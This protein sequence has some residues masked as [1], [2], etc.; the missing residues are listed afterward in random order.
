VSTNITGWWSCHAQHW[1][2]A[3]RVQLSIYIVGR[4][5]GLV[6]HLVLQGGSGKYVYSVDVHHRQHH[7]SNHRQV[8][9]DRQRCPV[10]VVAVYTGTAWHQCWYRH[11]QIAVLNRTG[12]AMNDPHTHGG[13]GGGRLQVSLAAYRSGGVPVVPHGQ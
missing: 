10:R 9:A 12:F 7:R 4:A 3:V 1:H 8:V 5:V 2:R 6:H 13:D 11:Q